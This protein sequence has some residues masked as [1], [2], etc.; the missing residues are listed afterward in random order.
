MNSTQFRDNRE[1]Y[2]QGYLFGCLKALKTFDAIKYVK[3][4]DN[5]EEYIRITD[6]LGGKA[7]LNIT[8]IGNDDVYAE[9]SKYVLYFRDPTIGLPETLVKTEAELMRIA[10]LFESRGGLYE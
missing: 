8:G 1:T 10:D 3:D 2:I 7:H 6:R 5:G 9:V 4:L